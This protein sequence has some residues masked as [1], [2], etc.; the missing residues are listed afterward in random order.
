MST[1]YLKRILTSKVY[2]V[3]V[4]SPLEFAP[5]VSARIHNKVLLKREDTQAVFS[6]KLR[7]AYNKMANLAPAELKRGVIAASA[8]NHAQGVALSAQRLGV[9]AVIVMP[10]TT[11]QVKVDAVRGWGGEVVLMGDSFSDSYEHA[12][13]LEKKEKL[14]FVHPFDDPD[15]IAGQGTIGMEILRQ[16]PGPIDAIFVAIGGGGLIAGVAAYVKQ[17]RPEIKIIGVQTEDSDAMVRSIKAG[18]RVT[19]NDVGLFSDGTA[20]KQVGVETF[21]LARQYVDDYVLVDTDAIC[22]GI[23]DVFQDTRSVLEPA[24]ALALAGAKRYAAQNK[25][26]DKTLVAIT[27]GANMNFDRLRFVAERADVGEAREAVFALTLP[28]KRGSFLRLCEAVGSR[29]VTEFN[30]RISDA[31][32]AHVFVGLQIRSAAEPEKLANSFRKKG[33]PTIDLTGNEMAKTHLRYM[34]GGRSTLAEHELLFR[35]EFPE[36]PGALMK[37]LGAMNPNWNI[38]LFHYRNQGDDYGR[39]LVGIQVPPEDKKDFKLFL[40]GLGYP[41]WNESDNP[42]YRLFL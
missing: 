24:G 20:V 5:Q 23:K 36:R 30:Y 28:E 33:F 32:N 34:V 41:Y 31:E 7:G 16:H 12:K 26:K 13:I 19:L 17:L 15:V 3:A 27:C 38:S 8:G 21:R 1:D 14:T 25:W 29:A 18:R 39:I 35:F 40:D 6:F 4:E 22:A 11:P 9:R 2:D 42:A 10:V 37:F